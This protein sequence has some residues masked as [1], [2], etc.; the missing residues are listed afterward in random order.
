MHDPED[1]GLEEIVMIHEE[2]MRMNTHGD[3]ERVTEASAGISELISEL[4]PV[5]VNPTTWDDGE[6]VESSNFGLS[7]QSSHDL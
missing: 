6:A 5:V 3:D 7:E 4:D 1:D 2:R